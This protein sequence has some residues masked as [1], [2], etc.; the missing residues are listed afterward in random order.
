[1]EKKE[2]ETNMTKITL[3]QQKTF[4]SHHTDSK[5]C[6]DYDDLKD[7]GF[8]IDSSEDSSKNSNDEMN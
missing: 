1:K 6:T 8:K 7:D 3:R 5:N 2:Q 4:H